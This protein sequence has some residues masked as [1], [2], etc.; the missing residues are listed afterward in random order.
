[1]RER[2]A[3]LTGI[4]AHRLAGHPYHRMKSERVTTFS[5]DA[6]AS[7]AHGG[8]ARASR[9]GEELAEVEAWKGRLEH[10]HRREWAKLVNGLD[11]TGGT[12]FR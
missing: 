9:T 5:I 4:E 7:V 1:M 3:G 2:P 11:L 10:A 12:A 8:L 6:I